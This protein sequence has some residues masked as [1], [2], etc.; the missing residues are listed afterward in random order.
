MLLLDALDDQSNT[1]P[2]VYTTTIET[3]I[4]VYWP[5]PRPPDS[6]KP[7]VILPTFK[8]QMRCHASAAGAANTAGVVAIAVQAEEEKAEFRRLPTAAAVAAMTAAPATG[9]PQYNTP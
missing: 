9:R 4:R 5:R 6:K 3:S 2:S 8:E 7:S 1:P